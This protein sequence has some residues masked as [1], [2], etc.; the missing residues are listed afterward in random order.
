MR[1]HCPDIQLSPH[2]VAARGNSFNVRP[3]FLIRQQVAKF[4]TLFFFI[5]G[6]TDTNIATA[7]ETNSASKT[8]A[9]ETT[10]STAP[11]AYVMFELYSVNILSETMS[12]LVPIVKYAKN[13]PEEL[14]QINGY[15]D[16]RPN[17]QPQYNLMLSKLR[18]EAIKDYLVKMGVDAKHIHTKGIGI[19]PSSPDNSIQLNPEIIRRAEIRFTPAKADTSLALKAVTSLLDSITPKDNV[20]L[21]PPQPNNI[22]TQNPSA[23]TPPTPVDDSTNDNGN[24]APVRIDHFLVT[25][26]TLLDA[27][28]VERLMQPFN[29]DNRTYTDIQL[30]LEALEG[31]YRSAGYSAVHV[32]LPEQEVTQGTITLQVIE[33]VIGKVILKGN[34]F[35]DKNNIRAALP[36]L[37]EGRTPSAR[38]LSQNIRLANESPTRKID[39]VL[40]V[41]DEENT[42]D[43]QVNVQDTSPHKLIATLDNNGSSSTGLYRTG[44]GYQH[45]NL[46]N[47]DHA[48]TLNYSTSPDHI[49]EVTSLSG[50][51]RLPLYELGDSVDLIAAHSDTN[52]GTTPLVGGYTLSFSGKGDVYGAH[53][54][55][56]MPNQGDYSS[57]IIAGLDYR[58]YLNNCLINGAAIC[59]ASGN[60][61]TV[62]PISVTYS[63][64]LTKPTHV[65]DYS[66]VLIHNIPGG[67][68]GTDSDFVAAKAAGTRADYTIL[69]FNG[70]L[71]GVFAQEWQYRA[72][73]NLQYTRDPLVAYE[74]FGLVGANSVRG[75]LEREVSNDE[76][77]VL[78]F[79]VYT[80]ELAPKFN[81]TDGSFRLLAFIDHGNGWK[82][83]LPGEAMVQEAVGSVGVGFRSAYKYTTAKLDIARVS[84]AG[85][86][87]NPGD[88]RGTF[89]V[90]MN[91]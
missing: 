45:N 27:G 35:Y 5:F 31:A 24:T 89:S 11:T 36:A 83:P 20:E 58:A 21:L 44:I 73:G 66:T 87:K 61:L 67:A 49:K 88:F 26:N 63:G 28:L 3:Y 62:H 50:S 23:P 1:S 30:A 86:S 13:H 60:D 2:T 18:A 76:G 65:I 68:K 84:N 16:K 69:R 34:Q 17:P 74:S 10:T 91:W 72:A 12:R 22:I 15:G 59:G 78:N 51:Y 53:Y 48:A 57:K 81:I 85:G 82:V 29:G 64:T 71:T 54:N 79:E 38:K 4:A 56:N 25:G 40:A 6:L 90:M 8:A 39:V 47:S 70:S 32:V 7:S 43:A 75:Y 77:F 80:P 9:L 52:A 41:G 42:V 46:F 55:H 37:T 33:T 19:E 14:L